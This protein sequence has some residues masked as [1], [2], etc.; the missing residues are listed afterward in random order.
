MLIPFVNG[1]VKTFKVLCDLKVEPQQPVVKKTRNSDKSISG[2]VGMVGTSYIG[3]FA[4][5]FSREAILKIVAGM[6]GEEYKEINEEVSDAVSEITNIVFGNAKKELSE[7]GVELEKSIPYTIVGDNHV[8][9]HKS[10]GPFVLLPF[11]SMVGGFDIEIGL[12]P[13]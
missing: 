5:S 4:I 1:V 7:L 12:E 8:I 11:T 10:S 2:V 9:N 6:L 3:S 13:K